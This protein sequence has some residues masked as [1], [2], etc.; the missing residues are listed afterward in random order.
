MLNVQEGI[1]TETVNMAVCRRCGEGQPLSLRSQTAGAGQSFP[2]RPQDAG[3]VA[4][5]LRQSK[6]AQRG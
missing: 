6:Y 2:W 5:R 4:H 1:N 3:H